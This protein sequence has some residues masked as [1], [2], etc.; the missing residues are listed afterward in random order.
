MIET[1]RNDHTPEQ[2]AHPGRLDRVPQARLLNEVLLH[3]SAQ[4][5]TALGGMHIAVSRLAP[6]ERRDADAA[7]DR[8]AALLN[9]NYYALL[10][11]SNNLSNA[12]MLLDDA[13]LTRENTDIVTWLD[14]LCRQASPLFALRNVALTF[15]CS[16][17][18]HGAAINRVCLEQAVW[19][20]LSNA[21][22]YTPKE[23][24]V[25]VRISLETE[26]P[27]ALAE[28]VP[29]AQ[30]LTVSVTDNGIG[31]SEA[32]LKTIFE[33]FTREHNTTTSKIAGTGLGMPIVKRLVD[34]MSGTITVKSEPGRGSI[35]TVYLPLEILAFSEPA[36]DKKTDARNEA[37]R[38]RGRH[39]LIAED[40][41]LNAEIALFILEEM[42]VSADRVSDGRQCVNRLASA[43][44]GTYDAILM[45][46]QMPIMDGYEATRAIRALSDREKARIP[47]LAMTANTFQEDKMNAVTAG[48]NG[49]VA[50]PIDRAVLT[51]A[52]AAVIG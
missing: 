21:L 7:L 19:N 51:S 10:R 5:R 42:G 40:N 50:K 12:P 43:P 28:A 52:L 36:A 23:G 46:I 22:K 44:A 17:A 35:F 34:M 13:P 20:L 33:P 15:Q 11:L 24:H 49:H 29:A 48:M 47:I 41:D 39:V 26:L 37:L 18:H 31:M 25:E 45:D 3:V 38:I 6:P 4:L 27:A 16:A 1:P 32:Y 9:R 8:D 14:G 2:P 30:Y